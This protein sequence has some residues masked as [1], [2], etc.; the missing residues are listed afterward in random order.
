MSVQI[1]LEPL[2]GRCSFA[3]LGGGGLLLDAPRSAQAPVGARCSWT[4]KVYDHTVIDKLQ[5]VAGRHPGRL[6]ESGATEHPRAARTGLGRPLGGG[7][8]LPNS[9]RSAEPSRRCKMAHIAQLRAGQSGP[10]AATQPTPPPRLDAVGHPGHG[11][12]EPGDLETGRR[13]SEG[14]GQRASRNTYCRHVIRFTLAGYH[15]SLLSVAYP[16]DRHGYEYWQAG[17]AATAQPTGPGHR[18]QRQQIVVRSDAEQ[19]TDE[20]LS[21][22]LWCNFQILIKGYS[23]R[24]TQ[25]WVKRTPGDRVASG[26]QPRRSA[27]PHPH[28]VRLRLGRQLAM[29]ICYAGAMHQGQCAPTPPYCLHPPLPRSFEQW[30][31][32]DGR[33]GM[34]TEIRAQQIG[35]QPVPAAETLAQRPRGLAATHRRGP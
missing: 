32:Y 5:D 1:A 3:P 13:Q 28:P 23:G 16:G 35:S 29:L 10:L 14:L 7:R 31:L 2:K 19:G 8:P 22:L 11:S 18:E 4:L 33:G 34:E 27:G 21:Y 26:T 25:A 6:P 12:D 15:E 17:C 9:R 20:I 24:R 30:R